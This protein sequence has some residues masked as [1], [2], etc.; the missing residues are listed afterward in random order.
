MTDPKFI[1]GLIVKP[2][3]ERAPE[4]V[5]CK[6]SIKRA[7][8]IAWLQ[9]QEGE[10]IN[11][12]IKQSQAGK[13]YAQVDDWK[14]EGRR[15]DGPPRPGRRPPERQAPQQSAPMDDFADDDIPF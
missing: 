5:L 10:W 15:Q 13:L 9:H 2:K 4:Y 3:H 6:L 12:D 8:L 14:P 1:S 7:E 11:A